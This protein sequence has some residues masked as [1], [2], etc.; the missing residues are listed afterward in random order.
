MYLWPNRMGMS[1]ELSLCTV[2]FYEKHKKAICL[3]AV[4]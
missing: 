3:I 4:K 2:G 1:N